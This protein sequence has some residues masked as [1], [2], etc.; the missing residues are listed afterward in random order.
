MSS[1]VQQE[2]RGSHVINLANRCK[3]F[4]FCSECSEKLLEGFELRNTVI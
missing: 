4:G 1:G 3:N 2:V